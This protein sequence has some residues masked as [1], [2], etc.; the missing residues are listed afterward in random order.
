MARR[1]Y[2]FTLYVEADIAEPGPP[3][4]DIGPRIATE[5]MRAVPV[6]LLPTVRLLGIDATH[7]GHVV[8]RAQPKDAARKR[9]A[10]RRLL[11]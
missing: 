11:P 10:S 7:R 9:N 2:S 3:P 6:S 4:Q 5:I 1:Y 8:P